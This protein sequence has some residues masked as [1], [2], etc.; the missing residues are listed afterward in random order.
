[1]GSKLPDASAEPAKKHSS[2][3][4][5]LLILLIALLAAGGILAYTL[6]NRPAAPQQIINT[7]MPNMSGEGMMEMPSA[8]T[9]EDINMEA[10]PEQESGMQD[11]TVQEFYAAPTPEDT[12]P[13]G[14]VQ[15]IMDETIQLE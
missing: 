13:E 15:G 6:L 1:M 2:K 12:A 9:A 8:V 3:T 10:Q 11:P 5:L 4:A 14:Q 7:D